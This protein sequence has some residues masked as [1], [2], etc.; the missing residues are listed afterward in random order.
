MGLRG[1]N[2]GGAGNLLSLLLLWLPIRDA[3]F[4]IRAT[5]LESSRLV[6]PV[7]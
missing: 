2:L 1:G 4:P 5:L 6:L 7:G 3:S